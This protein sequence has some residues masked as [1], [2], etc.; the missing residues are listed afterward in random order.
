M[1]SLQRED[2]EAVWRYGPAEPEDISPNFTFEANYGWPAGPTMLNVIA[3]HHASTVTELKFCGYQGAPALFAPTP[4]TTPLLS[5]LKHFH[6]L[7]CLVISLWFSTH[8]EGSLRDL[9]VI[10]YWLNS[11]SPASTALVR[12]TDEEPEGWEKELKTKYAPDVLAW[13]ITSFLGPLLSE[14]AKARQG[15][16]NVR[17]SFCLGKYGGIFDVDL[18]VGR[19]TLADVCLGFKGPREELEPERRRT[20]LDGRRWF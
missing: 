4:L 20:K 19:G 9:D 11:R 14:Q 6:N 10:S 16:V 2:K 3:A 8:F 13:R 7:E 17:A 15:G 1:S 12:V 5:A 18:N